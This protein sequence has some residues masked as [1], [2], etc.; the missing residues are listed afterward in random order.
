M[1][2]K[3]DYTNLF[4]NSIVLLKC[5]LTR[6]GVRIAER[7]CERNGEASGWVTT[8]SR[9][10]VPRHTR[11]PRLRNQRGTKSENEKGDFVECYLYYPT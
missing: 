11:K 3:K 6:E 1:K 8:V 9:E 2:R 4:F 10:N 7:R 5:G